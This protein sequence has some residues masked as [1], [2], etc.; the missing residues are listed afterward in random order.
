M[1]SIATFCAGKYSRQIHAIEIE[2]Y[3]K[4][5]ALLLAH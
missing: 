2:S 5:S 3:Y 1:G 4:I